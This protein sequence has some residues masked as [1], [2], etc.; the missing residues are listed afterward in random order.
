MGAHSIWLRGRASQVEAM[1][2]AQQRRSGFGLPRS[3]PVRDGPVKP[4]GP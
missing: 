2:V 4:I 1:D 3:A